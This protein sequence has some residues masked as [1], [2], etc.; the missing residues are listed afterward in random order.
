MPH[1]IKRVL[2]CLAVLVGVLQINPSAQAVQATPR[3]RFDPVVTKLVKADAAK[4]P[5]VVQFSSA[6]TTADGLALLEAG[7]LPGLV[8]Y[9]VVPA[10]SGVAS[11]AAI[12]ALAN[13]PRVTFVEHDA[14]IPYTLDR[15]TVAG[16]ARQIWEASY[17]LADEV[18]TGG[19]TGRGIGVAI[20]DSG[21]D[22]T[23]PDLIW[24]PMADAQ[25]VEP[26]T[27]ANYKIV[28]RD[29]PGLL[30]D[31]PT[32]GPF[33]EANILA[34]DVPHSDNTGGHGTHVAGIAGGNGAASEGKYKGAAPGAN[35]IGYGAGETLVVTMGLAAFDHIH[36]HHAELGIRVVNNSWGGAGEWNPES[37]I[38]KAAQR[39][40]NDDNLA[41]VFAAGNSGGDGSDLQSSVWGNIP[42]VI[43]VANYYDRRGWLDDT[44]SRGR[45][46]REDTWPDLAAP[47]TQ[48]IST[49]ALGG[50]VTYVGTG[51]DALLD[52]ISGSQEPTVVTVPVPVTVGDDQVVVGNYAS[53]TGT[54]MA[55]PFVA[56]VI[57]LILEAN[58]DLDP[59]QVRDVL[60]ETANMPEGRSY[61]SDGFAVG[62]GVVDAA[63]A[64]A[65]AL[66]MR[67]GA[68]LAEALDT[69]YVD[70]SSEPYRLNLSD[71]RHLQITSPT[72]GEEIH[73]TLDVEGKLVAGPL[74][75]NSIPLTPTTQIQPTLSGAPHV[76]SGSAIDP[77]L[78]G[79]TTVL[80]G[81]PLGLSVRSITS[82][83]SNVV[84]A[85]GQ[86]ARHVVRK[87][88]D[89]I[90]EL[91][92]TSAVDS[93]GFRTD[94]E[95]T[96]PADASGAHVFDAYLTVGGTE[97]KSASMPFDVGVPSAI[98]ASAAG[99]LPSVGI[100][101][102]TATQATLLTEG[103]EAAT[104]GWTTEQN[105]A[106]GP[107]L[108][109]EWRLHENS[110]FALYGAASGAKWFQA[111]IGPPPA[112]VYTDSTDVS[113]VSPVIDL[114]GIGSAKAKFWRAGASESQADFFEAY[115][116]PEGPAEPVLLERLSR[117]LGIDGFGLWTES[118]V[119]DISSFSGQQ[120][121]LRFRFVSDA[122]S[123]GPNAAGWSVDDVV[124][125]GEEGE[126]SAALSATPTSGVAPLETTFNFT[127][128]APA[129]SFVLDF[130]DGASHT[131]PASGSVAHTY[132]QAGTHDA[133]LTVRDANNATIATASTTVAVAPSD[134]VQLRVVHGD[135]S[136]DWTDVSRS[137]DGEFAHSLD[138]AS[139]P[140]G[141]ATVEARHFG[142][143]G[144]LV[145]DSVDVEVVEAPPPPAPAPTVTIDDGPKARTRSTTAKFAF[146]SD[147][148]NVTFECRID[149]RDFASC[150]SPVTYRRL[151]RKEHAFAVRATDAGGNVG[152]IETYNWRVTN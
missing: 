56:G 79:T 17:G 60:R 61:T 144:R 52:E 46:D 50:P 133:V 20:V 58:P 64:V 150:T 81:E 5:V 74:T 12:K 65:V 9:Q 112:E 63:E 71:P 134:V 25:G 7:F 59:F 137:G 57:A 53:F 26:K 15:A 139:V 70:T 37:S 4:I 16:R 83:D 103:F 55:A 8:R 119:F 47:G 45:R 48:V 100:P 108:L 104:D 18:H 6:P 86:S 121:R 146:H 62:K 80:P 49:G 43:Q 35:L 51:Q 30:S 97:Y 123:L 78:V 148:P 73:T 136:T 117:T 132:T 99:G 85:E 28:G 14:E 114:A 29:S 11:A 1:V 118:P 90:A 113:L 82:S 122:F 110:S 102:N 13:N 143:E 10:V 128:P 3:A 127:Y 72:S 115:I 135:G 107:G 19:F 68:S 116:D 2:L 125:T 75:D 42:E 130:G 89:V 131:A 24:K 40:V 95:W 124:I 152:P 145:R 67:E 101:G 92:T 98:G 88:N 138:L 77:F 36:Q 32:T 22:A 147:T 69:A 66:K 41:V 34:V 91:S 105:S 93:T 21:I 96:V 33:L 76:Y 27:I 120:V 109:T 87:G 44:S 31:D 23:H 39:L 126:P 106:P 54:S 38:T 111:T 142:T 141:P 129:S 84:L 149:S 151:A 140:V 94:T